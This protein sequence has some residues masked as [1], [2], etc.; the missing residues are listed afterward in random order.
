MKTCFFFVCLTEF[1]PKISNNHIKLII[2]L[3]SHPLPLF[4]FPQ[5]L[6]YSEIIRFNIDKRKAHDPSG[7][8]Q[9][10][11]DVKPAEDVTYSA[12]A[13]GNQH[14]LREDTVYSQVV[15]KDWDIDDVWTV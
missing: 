1:Q 14:S 11:A 3:L 7:E 9:K 15:R 5:D 4:V 2:I 12:V 13:V 8:D 6:V 10:D